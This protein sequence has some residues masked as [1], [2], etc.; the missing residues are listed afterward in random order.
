[1]PIAPIVFPPAGQADAHGIVCW[2]MASAIRADNLLN[3]YRSGIFPWPMREDAPVPWTSPNPRAVLFFDEMH[4]P[5]TLRQAW[6]LTSWTFTVDRAFP[7][8]M[9]ACAGVPRPG[10][11]G[12]WI[13][14]N[15]HEGYG[16]L[17]RQ[18]HAHSVEV[19]NGNELVGGLYGV[20]PGGLFVGESM[21]HL[22][23]NA[24]KL[25]LLYLI[26]H[27]K[28]RGATW[29]DVQQLTPLM[30]QLGAR[31]IPRTEYLRMLGEEMGKERGLFSC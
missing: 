29:I 24:S 31:E 25:A 23:S 12:T 8:V 28:T 18:G 17:H 3:A 7:V 20:D 16:E 1:M 22:A 10:Q 26:N 19:W 5:R 6:K 15:M 11:A 4:I 30:R 2:T 27:L 9:Q 14:T 13:I 21:F